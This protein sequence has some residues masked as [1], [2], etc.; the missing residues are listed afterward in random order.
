LSAPPAAGS[1]GCGRSEC[2][3]CVDGGSTPARTTGLASS[4]WGADSAFFC[5]CSASSLVEWV[6]NEDI[7][8]GTPSSGHRVRGTGTTPSQSRQASID[9]QL[10]KNNHQRMWMDAIPAPH[11]IEK[12]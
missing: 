7:E 12:S 1:S 9:Q 8:R 11:S 10:V 3:E 2:E 6:V 4:G 5:C